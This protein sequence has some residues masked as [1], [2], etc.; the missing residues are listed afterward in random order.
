MRS[1]KDRALILF[2]SLL[3]VAVTAFPVI[4]FGPVG[5]FY[6][7]DPDVQYL[8]NSFVYI[9]KGQ[10]QYD[11]HPGTPTI[12]LHAWA[13]FPLRVYAKLIARMPFITWVL[14]NAEIPYY[15]VRIFQ[16]FWLGLGMGV[17]LWS[18][19][20]LTG[21]ILTPVAAWL[22]MFAY[23]VFPYFG[24]TIVPETT[25]FFLT[26]VWLL[27]FVKFYRS[28]SVRLCLWLSAVAGPTGANKFFNL[29]LVP[30][31]VGRVWVVPKLMR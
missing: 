31:P 1:N 20:K 16:S 14:F 13:M 27:I 17:F 21:A 19:H 15:Y 24:S 30:G 5:A 11:V 26:A 18:I 28:P 12:I 9:Q 7:I 3:T 22:A 6:T 23:S 4:K 8:S 25:S 10:I 2:F 29:T